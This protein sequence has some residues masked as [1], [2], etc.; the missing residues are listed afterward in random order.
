[1]HRPTSH[2]TS[3]KSCTDAT[4]ILFPSR[5]SGEHQQVQILRDL[6]RPRAITPINLGF[7]SSDL[8]SP[9]TPTSAVPSSQTQSQYRKTQPPPPARVP[10]PGLKDD[11]RRP[12]PKSK[13]L[14]PPPPPTAKLERELSQTSTGSSISKL[15]K[16]DKSSSE[17]EI[18]SEA[19]SRL[20]EGEAVNVDELQKKVDKR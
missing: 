2:P 10:V 6:P 18:L 3:T 12:R 15:D 1:M 19:G 9:D 5:E 16:M 20:N 14:P 11:P 13:A 7:G 8:D 4:R 17:W